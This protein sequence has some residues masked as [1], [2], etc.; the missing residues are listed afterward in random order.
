M[1]GIKLFLHY[2]SSNSPKTTLNLKILNVFRLSPYNN[3][4]WIICADSYMDTRRN[5]R[6][7]AFS[8]YCKAKSNSK[9]LY[10]L[11][12]SLLF[13]K[14]LA[15]YGTEFSTQFCKILKMFRMTFFG[16]V[17]PGKRSHTGSVS[18][19]LKRFLNILYMSKRGAVSSRW[20]SS[21]RRSFSAS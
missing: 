15:I 9:T 5:H 10:A 7:L 12:H 8:R 21:W 3:S 6:L 20:K 1:W 18:F 14:Q 16:H 2:S 19:K 17:E 13:L 11:F 4:W